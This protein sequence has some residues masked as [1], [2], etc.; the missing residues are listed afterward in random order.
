MASLYP[1][2]YQSKAEQYWKLL[3]LTRCVSCKPQQCNNDNM[4]NK[5][6][7]VR[8]KRHGGEVEK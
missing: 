8:F 3:S 2:K 5:N 7:D 1:F 4:S 6:S